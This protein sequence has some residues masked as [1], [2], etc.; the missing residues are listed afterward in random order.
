M[1]NKSKSIYEVIE[2]ANSEHK[3]AIKELNAKLEEAKAD[4]TEAGKK[5]AAAINNANAEAYTTA[6]SEERAAADKIEFYTIQLK[7]A[8]TKPLFDNPADRKAKA[9][10]VKAYYESVKTENIK[11]AAR[12]IKEAAGLIDAVRE[13]VIRS[14]DILSKLKANTSDK[15]N[16]ADIFLINGLSSRVRSALEHEEVKKYI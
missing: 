13:E 4:A 12:L 15:Y 10:E 2:N 7:N 14:N 9:E 1:I 6:K 11:K 3:A 8:E 16:N 5:A